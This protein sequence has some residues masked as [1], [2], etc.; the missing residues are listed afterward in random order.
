MNI[1]C[2]TLPNAVARL[3][4]QARIYVGD[5]TDAVVKDPSQLI[6]TRP[7]EK[8]FVVDTHVQAMVWQRALSLMVR[9]H[10]AVAQ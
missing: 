3:K 6:F 8:G 9:R 10:R 2:R 7:I 5:E 4:R 1:T